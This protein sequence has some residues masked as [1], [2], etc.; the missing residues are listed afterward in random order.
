MFNTSSEY[1]KN[2]QMSK[3]IDVILGNC[4][5]LVELLQETNSLYWNK[6]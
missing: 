4:W 3:Y 2:E 1:N 6:E 5:L